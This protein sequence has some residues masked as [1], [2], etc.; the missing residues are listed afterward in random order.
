MHDIKQRLWVIQS[1]E[2]TNA[3]VDFT[4]AALPFVCNHDYLFSAEEKTMPYYSH[5][6]K[7][8]FGTLMTEITCFETKLFIL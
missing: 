3:T 8:I 7:K 4:I 5:S 6:R 2:Q 1:N